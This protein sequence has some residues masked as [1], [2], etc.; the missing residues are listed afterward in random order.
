LNS[1]RTKDIDNQIKRSFEEG[2]S[3][4]DWSG[5]EVDVDESDESDNE[6]DGTWAETREREEEEEEDDEV[7]EDG[8]DEDDVENV[9]ASSMTASSMA[10][11][12]MAASSMT[13]SSMAAS[14]MTVSSMAASSMTASSM[15]ASSMTA[16]SMTA[17]SMAANSDDSFDY[18]VSDQLSQADS[19]YFCAHFDELLKK[20]FRNENAENRISLLGLD[21]PQRKKMHEFSDLYKL[22]HWTEQDVLF[23][24]NL[25]ED[26]TKSKK[27]SQYI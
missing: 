26:E 1:N 12:S 6:K 22:F 20:Y 15:T 14:S 5:D 18:E 9:V 27:V 3:I 7:G 11:S 10:A 4:C 25:A 17:S 8:E 13:V 21:G 24:S 2:E 19:Q 16:S 23:I